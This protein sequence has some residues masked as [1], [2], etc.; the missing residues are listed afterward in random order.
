M[1][2]LAGPTA[3]G[4]ST[5]AMRL[6]RHLDAVIINADSMQVY[7]ELRVI[8]ARP[9]RGDESRVPHRLYGLV[10]AAERFS[11]GAWRTRVGVEIEAAARDRRVAILV[12]GTGLYFRALLE[13]LAPIPRTP[14]AVRTWVRQRY[15][16]LG[17]K[18]FRAELAKGDP[19]SAARLTDPQRLVRAAEVL[20]ATGIALPAW[21][22][23]PNEGALVPP[24]LAKIV[25]APPRAQV[26]QRCDRRHREVVTSGGLDEA[27]AM[28][29]RRLDPSVP[30]MRALGLPDLLR[31][32][33]GELSLDEAV[34]GGQRAIRHY[35]KRQ[36][37]WIRHQ[38]ADW[39]RL[40]AV[41]SDIDAASA[42]IMT[43]AG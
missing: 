16:A 40:E 29:E 18:A 37:T 32:L 1:I 36:G 7:R 5:L 3:S 24:P 26:Y 39:S 34:E 22:V 6:A 14:E 11:V 17:A 13:G 15:A 35:A 10:P 12:G 4:K 43:A 23:S 42:L 9:S 38:M 28:M 33:R 27:A 41:G 19:I 31:H 30:A 20:E 25:L 2:L 21:R 8:T